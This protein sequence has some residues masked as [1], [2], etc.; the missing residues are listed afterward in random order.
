MN[1][2]Y[3]PLIIF[4]DCKVMLSDISRY[5]FYSCHYFRLVLFNICKYFGC[6]Q[7]LQAEFSFHPFLWPDQ[8]KDPFHIGAPQKLFYKHLKSRFLIISFTL[9][10]Y[11]SHEPGSPSDENRLPIVKLRNCTFRGASTTHFGF[12][13]NRII[14]CFIQL[15][16]SCIWQIF[17]KSDHNLKKGKL[18]FKKTD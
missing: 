12:L 10:H 6:H 7:L 18:R 15:I 9:C 11:L 1:Y 13:K 3:I 4:I 16:I 2:I 8:D 14:F 5:C 17:V